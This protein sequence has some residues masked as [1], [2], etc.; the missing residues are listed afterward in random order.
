MQK[1]KCNLIYRIFAQLYLRKKQLK[2]GYKTLSFKKKLTYIVK[3]V[4]NVEN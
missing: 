2:N 4:S 3:I 1:N